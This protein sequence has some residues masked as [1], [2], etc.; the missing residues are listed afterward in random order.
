MDPVATPY[1]IALQGLWDASGAVEMAVNSNGGNAPT[2]GQSNMLNFCQ[3]TL[4]AAIQTAAGDPNLPSM[5]V[6]GTQP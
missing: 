3:S 1:S 2:Q 5:P 4:K 6:P